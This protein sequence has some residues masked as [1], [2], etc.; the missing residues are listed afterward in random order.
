MTEQPGWA[1]LVARGRRKGYQSLLMPDFLVQSNEYGV[2]GQLSSSDQPGSAP[3][4]SRI[5]GLAAGNLTIAYVTHRLT[6]ADLAG[7]PA[8]GPVT[9]EFGRPLELLYGVVC[10][11]VD[12]VGLDD[13]DL[14][15]VHAEALQTYQRFLADESGFVL[16][17]AQ[18]FALRSITAPI[19]VRQPT[20]IPPQQQTLLEQPELVDQPPLRRRPRYVPILAIAAV[21]V[22]ALIAAINVLRGDDGK[23]SEVS[24]VEPTTETVSCD[25]PVKIQAKVTAE[26]A[27]TIKYHWESDPDLS[28]GAG[29]PVVELKLPKGDTIIETTVDLSAESNRTGLTQNLVIDSSNDD[30]EGD[31]TYKLTCK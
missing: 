23:I 11:G 5:D 22:I 10:R 18:P 27:T 30:T 9:D 7:T 6:L 2:L 21:A 3:R 24:F 25:E 15:I 31:H 19:P 16:A 8:V 1:F 20:P 28:A 13:T 12:I 29:N 14:A 17:S 4:I 26:K